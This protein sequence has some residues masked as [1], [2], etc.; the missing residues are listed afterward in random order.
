MAYLRRKGKI[1]TLFKHKQ[2]TEL[3][4]LKKTF[5]FF[6]YSLEFNDYEDV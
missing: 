3:F 5:L 1:T 2:A 6:T 4:F